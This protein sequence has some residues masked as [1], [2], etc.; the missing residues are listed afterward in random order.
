MDSF[1]LEEL[2]GQADAYD[3]SVA[4]SP[5]LDAFCSSSDW[6]L[7]AARGLM[8]GREP[9]IRRE[10]DAFVALMR[11]E[12]GGRA[13][14]EPLEAM[15][16][17][18]CPLVGPDVRAV[19]ET[20]TRALGQSLVPFG[21]V[22]C[23]LAPGSPRLLRVARA[24]E[25]RFQLGLAPPTRR[26]VADLSG[27]AEA[28]W[29]RRSPTF[30]RSLR[31]AEKR[32]R[33]AGVAFDPVEVAPRDADAVWQRIAAIDDRTWKG[34]AGLGVGSGE[35]AA[36]Y[37]H[38]LRRLAA[39][40]AARV[41]IARHEER[42]VGYIFGG[43]LGDGYRGL[44]FGFTQEAAALSLGNLLQLRQIEGLCAEGIV[45]Y[46]L[47]AEVPYKRRWADRVRETVTL[48]ATPG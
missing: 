5:D 16:G 21:L 47:G 33:R 34:E 19:A 38:M 48:V 30:R 41:I 9:W 26:E 4:A 22:L 18:A 45:T 29:S 2:E 35:M 23:G 40:R 1:S 39:R 46:D 11:T 36:F 17:L 3:R 10:G 25:R 8:P 28:W 13:W 27:G 31:K 6:V 7:P 37:A 24:L 43:V 44:Q 12:A 42:D 32:A 14:L 20:L 15:W